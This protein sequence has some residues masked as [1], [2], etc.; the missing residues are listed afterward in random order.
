VTTFWKSGTID[1]KNPVQTPTIDPGAVPQ[2]RAAGS[3]DLVHEDLDI[4]ERGR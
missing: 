3:A 1:Y 2:T 4:T